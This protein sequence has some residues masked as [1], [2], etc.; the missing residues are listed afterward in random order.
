MYRNA[1]FVIFNFYAFYIFSNLDE[2]S[3]NLH[4]ITPSL[5][6]LQF[7]KKLMILAKYS[8]ENSHLIN[9]RQEFSRRLKESYFLSLDTFKYRDTVNFRILWH[10]FNVYKTVTQSMIASLLLHTSWSVDFTQLGWFLDKVSL[11]GPIMSI[12]WLPA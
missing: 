5:V 7:M 10:I 8:K 11:T 2:G 12:P 3:K 9:H 1:K 6:S 4:E